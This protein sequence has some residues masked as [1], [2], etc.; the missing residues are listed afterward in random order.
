[1]DDKDNDNTPHPH[2]IRTLEEFD[3]EK[4]IRD[5]KFDYDFQVMV[6]DKLDR[7]RKAHKEEE[8]Q[9]V[10]KL[11]ALHKTTKKGND[12]QDEHDRKNLQD[13]HRMLDILY[14]LEY[15]KAERR[16]TEPIP[17]KPGYYETRIW[18]EPIEWPAEYGP[19]PK[20][21]SL[22][23]IPEELE[24]KEK[25]NSKSPSN[26]KAFNGSKKEKLDGCVWI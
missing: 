9:L 24:Q 7:L 15:L 20:T 1:M 3:R 2:R 16:K 4:R 11:E 21:P 17:D 23:S 19:R 26:S 18:H 5:Q 12:E 22:A 13:T 14:T 6:R 8:N 10:Q 25:A